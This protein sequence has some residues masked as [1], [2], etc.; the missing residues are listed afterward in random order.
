[1]LACNPDTFI[2]ARAQEGHIVTVP[3]RVDAG[4]AFMRHVPDVMVICRQAF[5]KASGYISKVYNQ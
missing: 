5:R 4:K 3:C 2:H 1:M